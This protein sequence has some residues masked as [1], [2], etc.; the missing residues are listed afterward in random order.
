MLQFEFSTN[1]PSEAVK[2]LI[3]KGLYSRWRWDSLHVPASSRNE[4]E[5]NAAVIKAQLSRNQLKTR[6]QTQVFTGKH[7]LHVSAKTS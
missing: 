2:C 1:S 5:F 7:G 4:L 3:K 6:C